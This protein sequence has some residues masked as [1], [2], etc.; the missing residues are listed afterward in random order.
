MKGIPG[1]R[2]KGDEA[3]GLGFLAVRCPIVCLMKKHSVSHGPIHDLDSQEAH[4]SR[5]RSRETAK[6]LQIEAP[7]KK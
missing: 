2:K 7:G 5:L 3:W 1:V 6:I 4:R